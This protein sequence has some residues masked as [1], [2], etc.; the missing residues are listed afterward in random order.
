[1]E[2]QMRYLRSQPI[3]SRKLELG[4]RKVLQIP[5]DGL[6]TADLLE[7]MSLPLVIQPAVSGTNLSAWVSH[8]RGYLLE[9]LRAFGAILF[10]GFGPRTLTEFEHLTAAVSGDL[11]EYS[12]RST[13]RSVVGNRV[14]TSTDYPADQSIPMHNEMSYTSRWPLKIWFYCHLPAQSGG[15]TPLA[16]SR[17]VFSRIPPEIR[18][19]FEEKKVL[20]VRN[21]GGGL[22]LSW[23]DVFQTSDRSQVESFCR[24]AG[25][26]IEWK[27]EDRLMTRQRCQA[28]A[29]HPETGERVWFN[30]A[31]LFHRSSLDSTVLSSLLASC[32]AEGLPRDSYYGDGTPIET[33][34]LDVIR[35]IYAEE[36]IVFPWQRGDLILVDNMLVA[37]G[38]KPFTGSRKIWVT[39]AEPSSKGGI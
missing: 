35:G 11:M 26:E 7:G 14:Y 6:V 16:D 3:A 32:G 31:H 24:E 27:G 17:K 9:E 12:F 29:C 22:D 18:Q 25:I 5:R 8:N 30:Q 37:H 28:V 21:Y 15:E 23:E 36:A 1:M 19:R 34:V 10:R 2:A 20:Y 33:A 4:R 39:M 13:P 38:R